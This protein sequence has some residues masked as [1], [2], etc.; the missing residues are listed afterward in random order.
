MQEKP[1]ETKVNIKC[2]LEII[3]SHLSRLKKGGSERTIRERKSI[4]VVKIDVRLRVVRSNPPF[5]QL[6]SLSLRN[7]I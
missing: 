3:F 1:S 5:K 2:H 7:N 4:F 6:N